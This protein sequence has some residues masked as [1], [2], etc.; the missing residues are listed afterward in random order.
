MALHFSRREERG[1]GPAAKEQEEALEPDP[2]AR[3]PLVRRRQVDPQ[4]EE[5]GVEIA[6][7]EQVPGVHDD[8]DRHEAD[9]LGDRVSKEDDSGGG[10]EGVRS[11]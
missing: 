1:Q 11:G 3:Q 10:E 6:R 5:G 2:G 8:I 4:S 7:Q 9:R